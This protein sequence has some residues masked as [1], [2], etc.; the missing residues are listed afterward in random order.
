MKYED[1]LD[2]YNDIDK[3]TEIV[4]S[5]KNQNTIILLSGISGV[6][7]SGLIEKL[8]LSNRLS[9][10]I[11]RVKISKS[12]VS[13]IDNLQY[14]NA[15]YKEF[16]RF[17]QKNF[18]LVPTPIEHGI[19]NIGN[20]LN[21]LISNLRSKWGLGDAESLYELD[22]DSQIIKKKDYIL[23][24]LNN[25]D[26]ILDIENIQNI[27]TQS[28]EL[29]MFIIMHSKKK[30]FIF[31]YTLGEKDKEHYN[32]FYKELKDTEAIIESYYVDKIDFD[33]A[34]NLAPKNE[35][36]D[37]SLLEHLYN[38]SQ[39]NLMEI[40]LA[41]NKS[42]I[43]YSN[44]KKTIDNLDNNEKLCIYL[45]YLSENT[46]QIDS[47]RSIYLSAKKQIGEFSYNLNSK[48]LDSVIQTLIN[49]KIANID[50]SSVLSIHDSIK[51]EIDSRS[52]DPLLYYTY[53]N[54]KDYYLN[55]LN[56]AD[57]AYILE[58]LIYLCIKFSDDELVYLLPKA[59]TLLL[60][61]KYPKLILKKLEAY[62]K[63]IKENYYVN[64]SNG[65]YC[66]IMTLVDICI[67][68]KL[69]N[70]A[71]NF[72][73]TVFDKN[74]R[75]HIALQGIIYSLQESN[76]LENNIIEL[77][78]KAEINSKLKLILELALMN[79]SMKMHS[80]EI[81]RKLG[82]TILRNVKYQQYKEYGYVL[83]NF[84]ELCDD[85]RLSL[86]YYKK[87]LDF[88]KTHNMVYDISSIYISLSMIHSYSGN[89]EHAKKNLYLSMKIDNR[90]S[91]HCYV[92]NNLAAIDIL[93]GNH[94]TKTEKNLLDSLLLS[95][96]EYEQILIYCNL[97]IYYCL[98]KDYCS[99]KVYANK[100]E[101]SGYQKFEYEDFKH[102]VFQ[103]LK[104]YNNKTNNQESE[105]F[106]CRKLISLSKDTNIRAS[107][108]KLIEDMNGQKK[109]DYFYSR[110]QFR[111]DFLGYWEFTIDNDL[112][113]CL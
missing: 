1:L 32:N 83:R 74:N 106:Y 16:V 48:S 3:L 54:L 31:E 26:I 14:F 57:D 82:Y 70:E 109:V 50:N 97:L 61:L 10:N 94:S 87:A 86:S 23:Y 27:D 52:F 9:N 68:H 112:D 98:V 35:T 93:S 104:F 100:I 88:F 75:Y 2:R 13:T 40:I 46:L 64:S 69:A 60:N 72:L 21:Y 38:V 62:S 18:T 22:E 77:I 11:I 78:S 43:N 81:S 63:Q 25:S 110:F 85:D 37:I 17:S 111:V 58:Q 96:S 30:T 34:K 80:V 66:F 55:V 49:R 56:D 12:S 5:H 65:I 113:H 41:A 91:S 101:N 99:A 95:S 71:Q 44:I 92:L 102:I 42:E 84:A 36:L 47:L 73:N 20:F 8:S 79:Y 45:I 51:L 28:I 39:G 76:N 67:S 7:K 105:I 107:T 29:L 108:K 89:L 53:S 33:I 15:V 59:K 4:D 103:N 24:L 6:G 90:S 19:R